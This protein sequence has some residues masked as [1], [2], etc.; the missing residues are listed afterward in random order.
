VLDSETGIILE[1][2]TTQNYI[3]MKAGFQIGGYGNELF[4]P[5]GGLTLAVVRY[6][7]STDLRNQDDTYD[8][9]NEEA[10]VIFGCDMTFG[11]NMNFHDE[12][13]ID[14]G[15]RYVKSFGLIQ[16][17]GTSHCSS[18]ILSDLSWSRIVF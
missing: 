8:T 6:S 7:V 9:I 14:L 18:G 3:R 2:R 11:L 1:Q 5:H 15:V 16:Q 4:R 12:W 13:D 10:K 17:L